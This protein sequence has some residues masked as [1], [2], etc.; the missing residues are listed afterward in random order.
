MILHHEFIKT[1]KKQG[2]KIAIVDKTTTRQL[3]YTETLIASLILSKYIGQIDEKYIGIMLPTSA[4]C[5]L[6]VLATL[7][8]GKVPVMLNYST[9]A[10]QNILYA[11]EKCG[12]DT[13][14]TSQTVLKKVGCPEMPGMVFIEDFLKNVTTT[15]KLKTALFVKLPTSTIIN[16]THR[17]DTDDTAAIIFTSGSE[18]APKGVELTHKSIGANIL[19]ILELFPLDH[20]YIKM[21]ILPLFHVFG[22]TTNLWLPL[23]VGMRLITYAN[24]LEAKTIARIIRDEKPNFLIGT[25]FFLMSYER[26][27]KPGDFDSLKLVVAGA[28]KTP[29]WLFET[30]KRNHGIEILEGYGATETSPVVS[31]NP[32]GQVKVGS[33][34]KPLPGVQV[35]ITDINTGE[36]LP[37]R[38]EGK[39]L[40]KGDIL[41]KGY[42]G[43]VEETSLK[44]ENG[45]YETGDMG[46]L[47][48]DGYIWHK[49]RLKR[50]VKIGGEMVSLVL[51]ESILETLVPE[52]VECCVV[53]IPDPRKGAVIAVATSQ[54][55][56]QTLIKKQLAEQ[57]PPIALPKHF[58]TLSEL[59]KM[60]SGK[61][62]FRT[63][64]QQV[65]K[66]LK[67]NN[68]SKTT[69]TVDIN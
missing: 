37:A 69:E 50:F 12:F 29:D 65:G 1:A 3:T 36:T 34:G 58:V 67:E 39:I 54:D 56:D 45:W 68:R 27:A 61:I 38:R 5:S 30:Y 60:G 25:P 49:G 46:V 19:G 9:G 51:I 63:T 64:T 17:A 48:E 23:I 13:V 15:E 6:A 33:I 24:P 44:I 8:A 18:K 47:D 43:D 22:F 55:I 52:G 59:P 62:D 57:L 42:L 14:L 32:P 2:S 28:D 41:M 16:K 35:K 26:F 10:E 53:E 31:V 21:A 66:C 7:F 4:G 40:V 20:T 11:K